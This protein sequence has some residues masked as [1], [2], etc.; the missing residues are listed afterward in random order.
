MSLGGHQVLQQPP[1]LAPLAMPP[2]N[3]AVPM[4]PGAPAHPPIHPPPGV[5]KVTAKYATHPGQDLQQQ[6]L[7]L[8]RALKAIRDLKSGAASPL[9][10]GG[11]PRTQPVLPQVSTEEQWARIVDP[12]KPEQSAYMI[13]RHLNANNGNTTGL[14]AR[15]NT[16]QHLSIIPHLEEPAKAKVRDEVLNLVL[17]SL[18]TANDNHVN[19][20]GMLSELVNLQLVV[21]SGV[22]STLEALLQDATTRKAACAVLGKLA[23]QSQ[24]PSNQTRA[25]LNHLSPL[26][27]R[28][29]DPELEY[30]VVYINRAMGWKTPR[31]SLTHGRTLTTP[32]KGAIISSAFFPQRDEFVTGGA[33]GVICVWGPPSN[34]DTPST[35]FNLPSATIPCS[36]DASPQGHLLAV[37]VAS[38]D[39]KTP[40]I[41]LYPVLDIAKWGPAQK[42]NRPI[43]SVVTSIK[44]LSSRSAGI[45]LSERSS[46]GSNNLLFFAL[47]G[48]T[49]VRDIPEA[50]TDYVTCLATSAESDTVVLSG[51]RDKT[52]RLWDTRN[53]KPSVATLA[54]HSMC[55]TTVSTVR[56]L[57]A[58][59]S[60]DRNLCIWDIRKLQKPV[61]SKTLSAP[62]LKVHCG[63]QPTAVVATTNS[64]SALTLDPLEVQDITPNVCY[65]E[66]RQNNET[67][68]VFAAGEG[69]V[70][71]MYSLRLTS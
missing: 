57:V 31:A 71:D 59:G 23:Q 11:V 36:M 10:L 30:D 64:I 68:V 17:K 20:A 26:I 50:H 33:D 52:V 13:M 40:Q 28:I 27:A 4:P 21:L 48:D 49:V 43:G 47:P 62:I 56:D 54:G 3:I 8:G 53:S 35:T 51:S 58:T 5:T 45:C 7:E 38:L 29:D 22:A 18:T 67:S 1:P 46:K 12:S 55:V 60:L 34:G 32:H 65:H 63:Q 69:S 41:Q 39:G 42:I 25:A 66:L 16:S 24:N 14:A 70:V 6:L 19:A 15:L 9:T 37:A 44:C 61:M 2:N